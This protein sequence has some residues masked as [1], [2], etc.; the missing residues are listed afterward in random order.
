MEILNPLAEQYAE[1]FTTPDDDLLQEVAAFTL[2]THP[3]AHML[4]G[5]VQGRVLE[6]LTRMINPVHVLEIGTFTGYSALCIARVL[7]PGADIHTIELRAE[8]AASAA[9]FFNKSGVK[10]KIHL[11][12]GDA[13]GII[14]G[15][16]KAWDLV[17]ID[18]DKVSYITYYDLVINSVKNGGYILADNVLFHGQ[19]LTEKKEGKNAKAIQA[20]N[21]YIKNDSRVECVLLTI[22]DGLLLIRKK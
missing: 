15:L 2:H 22:R 10:D 5:V 4:S 19:V 21:E 6:M 3:K 20:F 7:K 14:P 12:V 18:A 13:A 11:H 8:D 9:G 1:Q 16:Q 17:F